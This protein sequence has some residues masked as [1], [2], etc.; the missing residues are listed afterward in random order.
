MATL[1]TQ[2][3]TS[4]LDLRM[5]DAQKSEIELA[6]HI[7][8]VSVTQWSMSRLMESARHDIADQHAME[9]S[10]AAFN[11]FSALLED[12]PDTTFVAFQ[13]GTTRWD[14]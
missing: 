13:E 12:A 2:R 10:R 14:R 9:L 6:A 5:T 11:R 8:G 1:S 7:N 4:R 3:K